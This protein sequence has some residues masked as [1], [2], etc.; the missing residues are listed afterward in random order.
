MRVM[1]NKKHKVVFSLIALLVL[2]MALA[3]I[4][5]VEIYANED[6]S[7]GAMN[8]N[9]EHLDEYFNMDDQADLFSTEE[10]ARIRD[11]AH[12]IIM[13]E[14]QPFL[15]TVMTINDTLGKVTRDYGDDNYEAINANNPEPL[16]G[17][18]LLINMDPDD[19]TYYIGTFDYAIDVL[20]D[21]RIESV[22]D[23]MWPGMSS[24]DYAGAISAG[25][26]SVDDYL[27]QG[28]PSGQY[29]EEE[30]A[31]FNALFS[32]GIATVMGAITG[33]GAY[34]SKRR[35]VSKDYSKVAA[36]PM[37]NYGEEAVAE[38][39]LFTDNLIDTRSFIRPIPR[40]TYSGGSSSSGR[41]TTHTTGG[42]RSSGGG[43]R[44]F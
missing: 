17:V 1:R 39:S 22:L 19:R 35:K 15:I 27:A 38:Y 36:K 20:T 40:P 6:T 37:Y 3:I 23:D 11:I 12:E 25:L 2:A 24:G 42:G 14:N 32:A 34:S 13:G 26:Y 28:R 30:K 41:S 8:S 21:E 10:E 5:H 29:R 44:S 31:P 9:A 7:D 16:S 18:Y 43:G 33:F 4:N